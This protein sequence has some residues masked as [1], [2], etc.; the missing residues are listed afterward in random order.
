M[1][2]LDTAI[3]STVVI[4][5]LFLMYRALK[6]PLDMLF[7]LIASGFRAAFGWLKDGGSQEVIEYG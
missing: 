5:G 6:E 7:G 4:V 2:W 1:E 3:I